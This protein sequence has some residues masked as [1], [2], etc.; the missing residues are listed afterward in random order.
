T[1]EGIIAVQSGSAMITELLNL[2]AVQRTLRE[3]F[4]HVAAYKVD[5][6][7]FG[8]PWGFSVASQQLEPAKLTPEEI[9]RRIAARGLAHLRSYD[10]IT[11]L[12]MFSL[13]KYIRG[14]L[15]AQP[16]LITDGSPLF[17][18]HPG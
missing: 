5:M 14:A 8:G 10:G 16:R 4:R 3:V 1:D 11:H 13:P 7:C 6:P 18:Y 2:S 9:D 12:G 15:A 17:S